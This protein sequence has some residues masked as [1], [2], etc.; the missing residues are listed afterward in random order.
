MLLPFP[1]TYILKTQDV[2]YLCPFGHIIPWHKLTFFFLRFLLYS[3]HFTCFAFLFLTA[4]L[5]L[6]NPILMRRKLNDFFNVTKLVQSHVESQPE[7]EPS[8]NASLL[9]C[10][11]V[12]RGKEDRFLWAPC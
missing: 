6:I 4:T 7:S 11:M 5:G 3:E 12:A 10:Q 9:V 1:R 8:A 2:L